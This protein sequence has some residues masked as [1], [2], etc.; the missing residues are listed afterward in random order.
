[1][2]KHWFGAI[3]GLVASA[4]FAVAQF[5]EP[6]SWTSRLNPNAE[7]RPSTT[8][9]YYQP[10][11]PAQTPAPAPA[12]VPVP[13]PAASVITATQ[14]TT[15]GS[16]GEQFWF[17]GEYLYWKVKSG[18]APETIVF[19]TIPAGMVNV[20]NLPQSAITGLPND[21]S[22]Y[23][24]NAQSGLR[25][26][27]GYW[28]DSSREWA[29]VGNWFQLAPATRKIQDQSDGSTVIGPVFDDP[30]SGRKTILLFSI[31]GQRAAQLDAVNRDAMWGAEAN[32]RR[33][34]PAIFFADRLDLLVGIRY[35]Q[36]SDGLDLHGVSIVPPDVNA[37]RLQTIS[38]TD[39]FGVHNQFYG[40]QIGLA[41]HSDIG[42]LTLDVTGKVA[43][44]GIHEM[45]HI[46]GSTTI[47]DATPP[48][49]T[50]VT[51]GG[52]LTEPTNLGRFHHGDFAVIPEI[53]ANLGWRITPWLEATVGY[54]F[55][56]INN[57]YRAG[58]QIETVD[59][60]QVFSSAA[61]VPNSQAVN[62]QPPGESHSVFWVQGL[63]AG[64]S[65][66]F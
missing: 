27:V 11:A 18:H 35:L 19:G 1:M 57:L 50:T 8:P 52:V 64:L 63:N 59:G 62:P 15:E 25:L 58:S 30:V 51:G 48:P 37:P 9:V 5:P 10:L 14:E 66:S 42:P 17:E 53:T 29:F 16:G 54:N 33:Q 39:Q 21:P 49:T 61:F 60:R 13:A 2:V 55:L 31:P 22:R 6:T 46:V 3:S 23:G 24:T 41:S 32:L 34:V 56:Y 20:P 47:F 65:F 26:G 43:L 40:G 38:Y 36:F 28:L 12:P 44:G 45:A 7:V 4:G